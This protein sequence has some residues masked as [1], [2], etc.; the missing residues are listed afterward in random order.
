M[1]P[2]PRDRNLDS[3]LALLSDGYTFIPKRC[4]RHR[5]DVFETR[6]MLRRVICAAGED[7]ARMFYEPDRFTRRGAL[8]P[9]A[10]M[11]LQD[12]GSVQLLDGDAHRWRKRMFMSL[13]APEGI[14]RLADG[15]ERASAAVALPSKQEVLR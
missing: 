5:S 2:F 14:H 4:Q 10:L 8:P 15:F 3:T 13:I 11:L 1:P 6:L 7:A 9:T 12:R